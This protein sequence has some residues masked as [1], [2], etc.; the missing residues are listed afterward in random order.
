MR[1]T[2]V[3]VGAVVLGYAIGRRN[4]ARAL[5]EQEQ[6]SELYETMRGQAKTSE[7]TITSNGDRP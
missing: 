7:V 2:T 6:E 4:I 1:S 3:V 5:Q